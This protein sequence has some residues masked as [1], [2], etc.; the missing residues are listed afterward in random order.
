MKDEDL[1]YMAHCLRRAN[2]TQMV[3]GEWTGVVSSDIMG[4]PFTPV[5]D[6]VFFP[7]TPATALARENFKKTKLLLGEFSLKQAWKVF[8]TQSAR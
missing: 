2:A 8:Q 3:E 7:D 5:Y 4:C 1:S 6:G